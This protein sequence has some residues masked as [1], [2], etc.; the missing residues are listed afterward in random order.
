MSKQDTVEVDGVIED[1]LPNTQFKVQLDTGQMII[2]HLSGKMR[3]H[4][5]R[6][7][8]GDRVRVAMSAYDLTKGRIILR[9]Q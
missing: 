4:R 8:P 2:G 7:M 5:I 6:V 3:I 1:T 9:L